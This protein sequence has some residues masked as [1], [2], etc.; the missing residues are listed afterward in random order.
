MSSYSLPPFSPS[1]LDDTTDDSIDSPTHWIFDPFA[2]FLILTYSS[3]FLLSS[4]QLLAIYTSNHRLK[5]FQ[6][7]LLSLTMF[8]SFLRLIFWTKTMYTSV[9]EKPPTLF[10]FL[11]PNVLQFACFSLL[12][13]YYVSVV[14]KP[15]WKKF[16]RKRYTYVYCFTNFIL[17]SIIIA[18]CICYSP[19]L[20]QWYLSYLGCLDVLLGI[21][22]VVY[23]FKFDRCLGHQKQL[24]PRSRNTFKIMNLGLVII[25]FCRAVYAFLNSAGRLPTRQS[26]L[27]FNGDHNPVFWGVTLFFFV[28]E[29]FPLLTL[30]GLIWRVPKKQ[31]RSFSGTN[32]QYRHLQ[33]GSTGHNTSI[34]RKETFEEMSNPGSDLDPNFSPSISQKV[35]LSEPLLDD[36]VFSDMGRYDSPPHSDH[37]L[38]GSHTPSQSEKNS[39]VVGSNTSSND[40]RT[41]GNIQ[42][43]FGSDTISPYD[44]LTNYTNRRQSTRRP[45][46][47]PGNRRGSNLSTSA[48]R[49][50]GG[51]DGKGEIV[52]P[53]SLGGGVFEGRKSANDTI[54]E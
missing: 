29:C 13:M 41:F 1:L 48:P 44:I 47:S 54:Q 52:R 31:A 3:A 9:W 38:G 7:G 28:T 30:V 4:L 37:P 14:H 32:S 25:F 12:A 23:S 43:S 16:Y 19:Q 24:L 20:D 26:I 42:A 6:T 5:T 40:Q 35:N 51:I 46:I 21:M 33:R 50:L 49:D 15:E 45:N 39:F 10:L 36:N 22:L 53:S 8:M 27:D 17:V 11:F 34:H 2:L 18:L